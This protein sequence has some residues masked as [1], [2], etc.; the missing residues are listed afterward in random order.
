MMAMVMV[1]VMARMRT[2]VTVTVT[3]MVMVIGMVMVMAR[4][5]NKPECA[6][7]SAVRVAA[8]REELAEGSGGSTCENSYISDVPA[9]IHISAIQRYNFCSVS[10]V[11]F[12]IAPMCKSFVWF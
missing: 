1:M 7:T 10:Q 5:T 9:I 3:V 8:Q 4:M 12:F 2:T 6:A 11:L